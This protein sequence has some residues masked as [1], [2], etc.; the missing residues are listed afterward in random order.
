ME[1]VRNEQ[2]RER[3]T[4]LRHGAIGEAEM[5]NS[6]TRKMKRILVVGL[7]ST[8]ALVAL[9][10]MVA[11]R[12]TNTIAITVNNNSHRDIRHL[13]LAAGDPNNWGPD[14]L[15]GSTVSPGA[16]YTINDVSCNGASVRVVA[17]DGD[18]CFVY[19]NATCDGD[20]TWEITDA[21]APDCGH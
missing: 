21:T 20:Q 5:Q 17:E 16:S 1:I 12:P 4:T 11:A 3:R 7:M 2:H 19:H 15:N 13:Y 18:G 8:T 10:F 9:A 6:Y 14:Q